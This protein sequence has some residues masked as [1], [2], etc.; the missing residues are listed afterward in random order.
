MAVVDG[1]GGSRPAAGRRDQGPQKMLSHTRWVSCNPFRPPTVKLRQQTKSC[2]RPCPIRGTCF[3]TYAKTPASH[4]PPVNGGFQV[5]L[6]FAVTCGLG[7]RAQCGPLPS[8]GEKFCH[9]CDGCSTSCLQS[10]SVSPL[11]NCLRRIPMGH[12]F[13]ILF[14]IILRIM[15]HVPF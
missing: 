11:S 13:G 6:L 7:W 2:L 5:S 15:Y 3:E 12:V 4:A 14:R 10:L 9:T 8:V 1:C